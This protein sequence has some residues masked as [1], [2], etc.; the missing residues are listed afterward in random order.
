MKI[1]EIGPSETGARGGMAEVIR[2][3][4]KS[5]SLRR[6]FEIDSFA[7]YIDG[8]LPADKARTKSARPKKRST[9]AFFP[10][11]KPS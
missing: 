5:G 9:I 1:L 11:S 10:L 8:S 7:S 3:I 4:R 2:D 6:E